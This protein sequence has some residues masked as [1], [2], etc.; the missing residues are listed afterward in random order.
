MRTTPSNSQTNERTK[1][2]PIRCIECG[3]RSVRPKNIARTIEKAHDGRVYDLHIDD[4]PATVCENCGE[5]FFTA[6]TDDAINSALRNHIGLLSPEEIRANLSAL[7]LRQKD[8]SE[9]LGIAEATLSRWL[10][11]RMIQ[12][13]AMDNLLRWFFEYP[14]LRENLRRGN[15]P[16]NYEA[17]AT[18]R[19]LE[20][21]DEISWSWPKEWL[22]N[23]PQL[24]CPDRMCVSDECLAA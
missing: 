14:E 20:L 22:P 2:Y 1:K 5:V 15:T 11:G 6:D 12:S 4:L 23:E 19:I 10:S 13:R 9:Q 7:M 21:D 3:A 8:A 17:V 18:S 24:P 16:S